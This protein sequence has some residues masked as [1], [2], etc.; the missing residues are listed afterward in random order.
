VT[1]RMLVGYAYGVSESR[2]SG[3]ANWV[4]SDRFDITAKAETPSA[5]FTLK[6][7]APPLRT[8]LADRFNL[9]VHHETRIGNVYALGVAKRGLKVRR[10][11]DQA[12]GVTLQPGRIAGR[13]TFGYLAFRLTGELVAPV[14]DKTGLPG[15]YYVELEWSPLDTSVSPAADGDDDR[16]SGSTVPAGPTVFTA[17]EQQLGLR[18]QQGKG[19]IEV[20]VI[21][22]AEKPTLN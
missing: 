2:I 13:M 4:S 7:L 3:G 17:L 10:A 12:P 14:I 5:P 20:L 6:S 8:L 11:G 18:L 21:D 22:H 9:T 16:K 15:E 1:L 19:D